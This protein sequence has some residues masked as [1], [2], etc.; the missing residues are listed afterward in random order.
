MLKVQKNV[1]NLGV[2]SLFND[3]S[4]EMIQP[5]LPVFLTTALNAS[6]TFIGIIEG[7]ADAT[8]SLI[9]LISGW[10]SDK[11]RNRKKLILPGYSLAVFS[12]FLLAIVTSS[13][14]VL[15][16]RFFD[17]VGKAMRGAPRDA[18]IADSSKLEERGRS[19]G[20]Q[21]AM[22]H[23]GAFLGP[24]I[25]FFLLSFIGNDVPSI[26]AIFLFAAIPGFIAILILIF[27]VK[28]K[29][30][31]NFSSGGEFPFK[32]N[33]ISTL[34][35][36]FKKFIIILGIFTL[37]NST[38]VFLILK[39]KEAGVKL[40]LIPLLWLLLNFVKS[41]TSIPAGEISD[42][43]GRKNVILTAWIVYSLSYFGFAFFNNIFE[44][45]LIFGI[46]GIYHGLSEGTERAFIAD[47]VGEE[48]RGLAYGLYYFISGVSL[49]PASLIMGIIWDA[50]SST[51][52]FL[53]CTIIS[54]ISML[55]LLIFV[56]ERKI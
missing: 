32:F 30:K 46:Y 37:G 27:G 51:F 40:S 20:F 33:E 35:S 52:A 10:L 8:S 50:S 12:R 4:S 11:V 44:I 15:L 54:M 23:T 56:K 43:I 7:V 1:R 22:D 24:L 45:F 53:F 39:A 2:V 47:M 41:I 17:R 5:L 55:L 19:F 34:S 18:L 3:I 16:I 25:A 13:F 29:R 36:N 42:K 38:D 49:F 31:E 48:K 6:T 28:E 26:R 21:R 14:Q 9:K